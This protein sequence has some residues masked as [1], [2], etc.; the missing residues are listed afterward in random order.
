MSFSNCVINAFVSPMLKPL[1]SPINK[2]MITCLA[3]LIPYRTFKHRKNNNFITYRVVS[4]LFH[5][6]DTTS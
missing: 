6:P 3:Q 5:L 2:L 4:T 1:P